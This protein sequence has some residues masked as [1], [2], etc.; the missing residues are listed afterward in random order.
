MHF[1]KNLRHFEKGSSKRTEFFHGV[2]KE[3]LVVTEMEFSQMD[4]FA[5]RQVFCRVFILVLK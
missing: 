3:L 4:D 2:G 5:I 1:Q